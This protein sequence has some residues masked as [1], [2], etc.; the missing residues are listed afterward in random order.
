MD[1][2]IKQIEEH[3]RIDDMTKN[4]R[5]REYTDARAVYSYILKE[6]GRS[7]LSIGKE[8]HKNHATII[9][10]VKKVKNIKELL[11]YAKSLQRKTKNPHLRG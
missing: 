2:L 1:N 6:S 11:E 8:L 3:F 9:Y 5:L 7:Y 10:A 4:T